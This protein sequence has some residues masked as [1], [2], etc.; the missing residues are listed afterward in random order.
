MTHQEIMTDIQKQVDAGFGLQEIRTNLLAKGLTAA[1]LEPY[2]ISV[3]SAVAAPI[4][5]KKS[6][7]SWIM[8]VMAILG[9]IRA[10]LQGGQG[11]N[12]MMTISIILAIGWL[13]FF[14]YEQSKK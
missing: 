7:N 6:S 14:I 4:P 2:L 9:F 13:C 5:D 11:R 10:G 8:L 12:V 1:E 3:R